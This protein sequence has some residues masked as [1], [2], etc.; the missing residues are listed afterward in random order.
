[1]FY[2][3]ITLIT[4]Y[5]L[6]LQD[7]ISLPAVYPQSVC[8]AIPEFFTF[9]A[10]L[11]LFIRESNV[12]TK[13]M[14]I[15]NIKTLNWMKVLIFVIWILLFALLL[16]REVFITTVTPKETEILRQAESEEYQGIYFRDNKIGFVINRYSRGLSQRQLLAQEATMNLKIG[17]AVQT[18]TLSLKASLSA[19]NYLQDFQFSFH[20][21]F[22]Q[23]QANGIVD[24]NKVQYSL[25]TGT[26]TIR[27]TLTLASPP[28]LATSRRA[29]LLSADLEEGEKRRIP[30]F[31][32]LSLTS[33]ES[34]IEYRGQEAILIQ[35]RVQKLHHFVESFSGAR[36]NSWL[37]NSGTVVKEESPAGFIFQKEP[38]FKALD[39]NGQQ[40]DLLAAVA[41][42]PGRELGDI[43]GSSKQYRLTLPKDTSFDLEGGRQSLSGDILTVFREELPENAGAP[44]CT[45]MAAFRSA[46]PSIQADHQE[47]L[48]LAKDI[49]GVTTD[50]LQKVQLLADWV[51]KNLSKRPV[52]GLPDA[53]STLQSRQGDCNEHAALFAA[54]AR[55]AAVPTRIASGVTYH[56]QAFYY[57]A[58]NEVCL[59][60]QWMSIDTTTNQI[61]A[62]LSHIRFIIGEMQ[63]QMRLSSLLG[64][65]GIEP[66]NDRKN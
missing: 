42:V 54:L 32:P 26:N 7:F 66:V 12:Y 56:R 34:V 49:T 33:K 22:Y 55:A 43:S 27:D 11:V 31:D 17:E 14:Q 10:L 37:N 36:I 23:M 1:M 15:E 25:D 4:D 38:K 48:A 41:V 13:A 19:D 65:L 47:I 16:K 50:P 35:G 44:A 28:M 21:P 5:Y 53:I 63:E 46:S 20:S 30:W 18:I 39:L 24:G 61:P 3:L 8:K 60:K 51:Y 2:C 59:D 64:N 45:D 29:Y 58:W 9:M 40:E 57:H 52:L 6:Q 62:D